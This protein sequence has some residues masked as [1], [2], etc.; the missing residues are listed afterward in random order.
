MQCIPV[1]WTGTS[2]HYYRSFYHPSNFN[3]ASGQLYPKSK[4][5]FSPQHTSDVETVILVSPEQPQGQPTVLMV[6]T[7]GF[8]GVSLN[9]REIR[10]GAAN[11]VINH[12]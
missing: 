1:P 11:P 5:H 9:Y 7:A 2:G 3:P 6:W 12:R 8:F 10:Q 4:G